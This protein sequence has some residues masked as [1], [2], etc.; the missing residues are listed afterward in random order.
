ML[1]PVEPKVVAAIEHVLRAAKAAGLLGRH[2]HRR[3]RP[4]RGACTSSGFDFIS[5]ASD[6]RL[7]A[8]K[9]QESL[10]EIRGIGAP[11]GT[12]ANLLISGCEP[13]QLVLR[14]R[15]DRRV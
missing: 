8:L 11:D 9:S 1:D 12:A 10:A 7:L 3:A 2:P 4:T 5:L 13:P 6:S 14:L 15:P